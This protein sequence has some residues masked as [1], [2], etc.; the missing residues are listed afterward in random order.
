LSA[1]V[2]L[3]VFVP[4]E[5]VGL[6]RVDPEYANAGTVNFDGI[7]VDDGSLSAPWGLQ[8]EIISYLKGMAYEKTSPIKLWSPTDPAK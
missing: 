2:L 8:M 7:T 5:L 1:L 6:G 4:A 3:A